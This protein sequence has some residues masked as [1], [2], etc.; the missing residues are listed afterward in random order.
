MANKKWIT[1]IIVAFVHGLKQKP[2]YILIFGICM[3][4]VIFGFGSGIYGYINNEIIALYLSFSSF[5]IALIA[6]TIVIKIVEVPMISVN[7]SIESD[8][9]FSLAFGE[10][11]TK[12]DNPKKNGHY[13]IK[14]KDKEF[15]DDLLL[16]FKGPDQMLGWPGGWVWRPPERIPLNSTIT[17]ELLEDNGRKW[18]LK[19]TPDRL[20]IP[21]HPKE[22][23]Q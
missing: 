3:L 2:A 1:E 4:F 22:I 18:T 11:D 20:M 8:I 17:M 23:K 5:V 10:K 9:L 14:G 15:D 12:F 13:W 6:A 16:E 21:L 7:N 19:Q